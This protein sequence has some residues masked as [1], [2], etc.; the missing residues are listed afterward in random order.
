MTPPHAHH[1]QTDDEAWA[2][3]V[4]GDAEAGGGKAGAE[5]E[6][7]MATI[8]DAVQQ[9]RI[10]AGGRESCWVDRSL[11]ISVYRERTHIH[12]PAAAVR[13]GD[14]VLPTYCG[15]RHDHNGCDQ[16][17]PVSTVEWK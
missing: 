9:V 1:D 2:V 13:V 10:T 16:M 8:A 12:L 5:G 3:E 17:I 14:L 4:G 7:V 15:G 6:E 11:L